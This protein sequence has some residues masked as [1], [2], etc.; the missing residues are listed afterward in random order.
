M[1]GLPEHVSKEILEKHGIRTARCIFV[2]GEEEA[3][4]AA[5]S[6]GFPV[7]MKVSSSKI[8]HKSDVGGVVLDVKDEEEVRSAFKKLMAID[9]A[10][11]VNVQPMLKR[12]IEVIVGVTTDD[13]FGRV[14]MFGLGGVFVEA[15]GDVSFRLI[16]VTRRDATEMIEEVKGC[17]VLKGYRGYK[18]DIDALVDLLLKV[19]D[20]AVEEGVVE[21]DLNPV[22]VYEDGYAV[23]DARITIAPR[24]NT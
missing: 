22:F 7:V 8:V 3:V 6:I 11:G 2:T 12:G 20:V 9:G 23:A 21:M 24:S 13:Q 16:P 19:S 10:E 1:R 18:A 17:K 5:R 15:L 14:L 4:R